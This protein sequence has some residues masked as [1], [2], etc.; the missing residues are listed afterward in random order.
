MQ[1]AIITWRG[2]YLYL[3]TMVDTWFYCY[4]FLFKKAAVCVR[5]WSLAVR[6]IRRFYIA[7]SWWHSIVV[8]PP[9]LPV[10]LPYP[11]LD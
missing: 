9:V 4:L 8:R 5:F 11:A 2:M 3:L 6:L 10:C 7:Y 1:L